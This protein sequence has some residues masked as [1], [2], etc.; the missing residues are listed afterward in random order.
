M[1]KGLFIKYILRMMGTLNKLDL[2]DLDKTASVWP[3]RDVE[4]TWIDYCYR[5]RRD[6]ETID[7]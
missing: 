3:I 2:H 4:L 5:N 1:K 6:M 7:G